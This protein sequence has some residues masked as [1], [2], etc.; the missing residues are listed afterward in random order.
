[1][2]VLSRRAGESVVIRDDIVVTIVRIRGSQVHLSFDAPKETAIH[3]RE[4]YDQIH[5]GPKAHEA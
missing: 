3:R 5:C 2:L 4:I 1:M